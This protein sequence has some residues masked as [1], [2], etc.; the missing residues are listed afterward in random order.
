MRLQPLLMVTSLPVLTVVRCR[1]KSNIDWARSR[2]GYLIPDS[3]PV[4]WGI[5]L[6]LLLTHCWYGGDSG[7]LLFF[8]VVAFSRSE[9]LEI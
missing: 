5:S 6:P 4:A 2:P 1:Q 3:V 8:V 9:D 7:K